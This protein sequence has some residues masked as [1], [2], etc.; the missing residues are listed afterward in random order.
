M[1]NPIAPLV[2]AIAEAVALRLGKRSD[3]QPRLM[4]IEGAAVY[5]GRTAPAI[6]QLINDGKIRATRIDTRVQI[7][8]IDLDNLIDSSKR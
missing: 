6:R 7:D 8:R 2:D 3:L 5:L 1:S 4:D